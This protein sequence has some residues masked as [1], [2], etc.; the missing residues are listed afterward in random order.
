MA[1][2]VHMSNKPD[3][4]ARAILR[5]KLDPAVK[6][7][8]GDIPDDP[9]YEVLVSG[10]PEPDHLT[11]S[12]N[13]HTLIVPWAGIPPETR[14]L[15][16]KFPNLTVRNSHFPGVPVAEGTVALMLA[17]AKFT[18]TADRYMRKGDWSMDYQ[19]DSPGILL[20]GK[21]ALILGYGAI[22]RKVAP[23]CHALGME[24]LATRRSVDRAVEEND[25][26]IYPPKALH[27][28]LPRANLLI[29][30]LPLTPETEGLI[31]ARELALLPARAVL[32]NVGRGK[33][34]QEEALY[35]ALK[36][37]TLHA[38]GIDVWYNYPDNR[39]ASTQT[40][41]SRY[42]FH[43]LDNVI[44]S[45]HRTGSTD[46]TERLRMESLAELLNAIARGGE[47]PN[48]VDLEAGY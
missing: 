46:E 30:A 3:D 10:R 37:G 8:F 12:P 44:M 19:H 39:E 14:E 20:Q 36:D 33:I 2:A 32:V 15:A 27:D 23:V 24:V 40:F 17:A 9:D 22:G 31:G 16:Q 11:A 7:S 18:V 48:R 5:D 38:A 6:L 45:P 47:V 41:P 42:P 4:E 35:N 43:K 13:L 28:L 25:V 29:V 1:L 21:T 34:V 26:T